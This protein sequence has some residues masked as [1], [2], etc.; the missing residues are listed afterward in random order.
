[1][2]D[3]C[4]QFKDNEDFNSFLLIINETKDFFFK[5]RFYK[6]HIS[7]YDVKQRLCDFPQQACK[8]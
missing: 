6:Y 3:F 2:E 1:M 7:P 8:T 5:K 4:K